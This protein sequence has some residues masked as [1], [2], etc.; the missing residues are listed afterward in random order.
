MKTLLSRFNRTQRSIHWLHALSFVVLLGTGLSLYLPALAAPVGHRALLRQL[1]L[2]LATVY[3]LGPTLVAAL[4]N[5]QST[6]EEIEEID[7]WE[8]EDW[9]WLRQAGRKRPT[10]QEIGRF[11][12]GQ[13]LNAIFTGAA[14]LLFAITGVIMW[15]GHRFP[16]WFTGN[17]IWL[18]DGL[19]WP[20][21][22]VWLGHIYFG[23]IHP[24]TRHSLRG[25]TLGDVSAAWARD[26]HC[27]WYV[28]KV[29][30]GKES[31]QGKG[32]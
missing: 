15:Q 32:E 10:S 12:A 31:P 9:Q 29:S 3:F 18:H 16:Q 22:A 30:D 23:A 4:G 1:H 20:A 25:M 24:S 2:W 27:L 28:D 26:H 21:L 6:R 19:T 17:A 7:R 13:K 14:G 5:R 11:N 8:P